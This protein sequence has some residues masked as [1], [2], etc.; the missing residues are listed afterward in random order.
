MAGT[1]GYQQVFSER[2]LQEP[3]VAMGTKLQRTL[4]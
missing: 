1:A 3:V 4:A 2:C